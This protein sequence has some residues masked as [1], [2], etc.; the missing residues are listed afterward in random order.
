MEVMGL[1][2]VLVN[3]ALIGL[4]GHVHR[5]FPEM[6]TTQ[7]ILL[8]VALEHGMLLLRLIVKVAIP[9]IPE[10]V[11]TEMAKVEFARR[12]AMRK[13]SSTGT[14]PTSQQP[15]PSISSETEKP[16]EDGEET[17][18]T[19]I[20]RFV[21]SPTL[22]PDTESKDDKPEENIIDKELSLSESESPPPTTKPK[23]LSNAW[24]GD[25]P[26]YHMTVGP[27]APVDWV[28]KLGLEVG[29]KTSEPDMGG[30]S[31]IRRSTD[32]L[33][34]ETS[35]DSDLLRSTPPAWPPAQHKFNIAPIPSTQ[36]DT[37]E[38]NNTTLQKPRLDLSSP[39]VPEETDLAAKK[40]KVKQSLMKRARS[41]AIFSLKLKE[42]RAAAEAK[43][44]EKSSSPAVSSTPPGFGH[45]TP[46]GELSYIPIEKLISVDDV[47]NAV[48]STQ[49]PRR[50]KTPAVSP[51]SPTNF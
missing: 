15:E 13:F 38:V 50:R 35:S 12:E 14:P 18:A 44:K 33:A 29:R 22:K 42:R 48:S 1:I 32:C 26:S 23:F 9:D 40:M 7:T 45:D 36:R 8:I 24:Q 31:L 25:P 39:A 51:S 4:S 3:C 28:H 6:S 43:A 47:A 34:K 49:L 20:G 16:A 41:V 11:A 21:V 37:K 5:M 17:A 19:S 27:H 10:W 30:A 2:A 46:S